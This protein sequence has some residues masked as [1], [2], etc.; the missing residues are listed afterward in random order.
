MS[1]SLKYTLFKGNFK[2][3]ELMNGVIILSPFEFSGWLKI[4]LITCWDRSI[5]RRDS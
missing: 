2:E 5:K 1:Y 3:K 4:K